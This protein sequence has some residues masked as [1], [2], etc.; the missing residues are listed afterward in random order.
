MHANLG[1][2]PCFLGQVLREITQWMECGETM[3]ICQA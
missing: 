3:D 2:L 1:E